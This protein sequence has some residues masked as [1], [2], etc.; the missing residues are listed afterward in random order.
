[1]HFLRQIKNSIYGRDFYASLRTQPLSYSFTYFFKFILLC[2][3]IATIY[4]SIIF[5]PLL[6]SFSSEV[7]TG[8]INHF[9]AE[10]AVTIASG[11]ASS[12]VTEPYF[13]PMPAELKDHKV[14]V[15]GTEP[16]TANVLVID[17]KNA[18]TIE[19]YEKYDA[20]AWLTAD[21]LITHDNK[22]IRVVPLKDVPNMTVD[23]AKIVEWSKYIQPLVK[24]LSV[25]LPV[26]IFLLAVFGLL[27]NLLYLVFGAL[28]IWLASKVF[29]LG[30][31]YSKSYQVGLHALTLTVLV[32]GILLMTAL[33]T[34]FPFFG[35]L[36]LLLVTVMNLK[37]SG[38][39]SQPAA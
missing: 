32:Q 31:N 15:N 23:H 1:M 37:G 39:S 12:N 10:L 13:I 21:S 36:L 33:W 34:P 14:S 19:Q 16:D 9:P 17:T 6:R 11:K 5:L 28:A 24:V 38:P 35:T 4:G 30:L 25:A 27:F 26:L 7:S 8:F 2:A 3:V 29:K 20:V 22:G 18:F